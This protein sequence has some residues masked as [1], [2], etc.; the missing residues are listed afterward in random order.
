MPCDMFLA[1]AQ[2]PKLPGYSQILR[3][4]RQDPEW[5]SLFSHHAKPHR[6]EMFGPLAGSLKAGYL[7]SV[8]GAVGLELLGR[9]GDLVANTKLTPLGCRDCMVRQEHS[10]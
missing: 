6:A 3:F 2:V 5:P 7:F 8:Q 1:S 9:V 4:P 10:R